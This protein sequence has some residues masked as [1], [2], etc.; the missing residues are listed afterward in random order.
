VRLSRSSGSLSDLAGRYSIK[1][2]GTPLWDPAI[3]SPFAILA[4][5]DLLDKLPRATGRAT[6]VTGSVAAPFVRR[7]LEACGFT[8]NVIACGKEIACLITKKDLVALDCTDLEDTVVIPGRAFVHDQDAARILSA[9]DA[10]APWYG[11]PNVSR[12]TA[13]RA[14]G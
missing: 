6:V 7:A 3:G 9:T 13:R 2:S 14:R 12:L 8:G 11:A 4:E 1:I 10:P 5:P